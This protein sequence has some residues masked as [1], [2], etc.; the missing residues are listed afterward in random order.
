MQHQV[1]HLHPRLLLLLQR[2]PG[3]HVPGHRQLEAWEV[4]AEFLLNCCHPLGCL[5]LRHPSCIPSLP[6]RGG[7]RGVRTP[8]TRA[9][10]CRGIQAG[11]HRNVRFLLENSNLGRDGWLLFDVNE[12]LLVSPQ[13]YSTHH[14][15]LYELPDCKS[16]F[17]PGA[18]IHL[19]KKNPQSLS[20]NPWALSRTLFRVGLAQV[21]CGMDPERLGNVWEEAERVTSVTSPGHHHYRS[22][23]AKQPP[24]HTLLFLCKALLDLLLYPPCFVFDTF[25]DR[26]CS[27]KL[28]MIKGERVR[29][30]ITLSR[31]HSFFCVSAQTI[32][33][34]AK[35]TKS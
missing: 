14:L 31:Q 10:G 6:T 12:A 7:G 3:F 30:G 34:I 13:C 18:A 25:L 15:W 17:N 5:A 16:I 20:L 23:K 24:T 28:S 1:L 21:C 32:T 22:Y 26:L 29:L 11:T 8:G 33:E 2:F 4:S 35:I 19:H 27:R 9:W